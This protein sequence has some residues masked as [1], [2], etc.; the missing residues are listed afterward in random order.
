MTKY[1]S[2]WDSDSL[3]KF[4]KKYE[5]WKKRDWWNWIVDNLSF[6]F[7][8]QRMEDM[9][10]NPFADNSGNPF[11]TGQI[12]TVVD[13]EDEDDLR[14]IIVEVKNDKLIGYVPLSDLQVTSKSNSNFWPVREYVVWFA[15]Q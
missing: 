5:V 1:D 6:P 3:R 9:D 11:R 10:S 15:N 8:A 13:V 12:M 4:D 7:E 14:G 2:S